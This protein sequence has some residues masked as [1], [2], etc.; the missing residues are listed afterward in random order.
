MD[1]FQWIP[2][3]GA[4]AEVQPRLLSCQFGDGYGQDAG[5]GINTILPP[6]SLSFT[7]RSLSEALAIEAFLV[8]QAG[9][10][11]FLWT[12]PGGSTPLKFRCKKWTPTHNS[13]TNGIT[14]TFQQVPA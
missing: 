8:K 12:P 14:A 10:T 5:D 2:D 13:T 9:A 4:S 1:T 11:T 3:E 6:W 7:G